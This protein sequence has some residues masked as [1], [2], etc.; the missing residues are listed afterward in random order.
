MNVPLV[1]SLKS[2]FSAF[3]ENHYLGENP[4]INFTAKQSN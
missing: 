1:F 2:P 3:A 4:E